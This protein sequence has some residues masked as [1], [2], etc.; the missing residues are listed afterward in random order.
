[1]LNLFGCTNNPSFRKPDVKLAHIINLPLD[2]FDD[3]RYFKIVSRIFVR[4]SMH[5][6]AKSRE[7]IGMIRVRFPLSDGWMKINIDVFKRH[8]TKSVTVSYVLLDYNARIIIVKD[9]EIRYSIVVTEYLTV[10]EAI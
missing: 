3:M 9:K 10:R 4:I 1:M 7:K 5:V 2:L 8:S 6:H